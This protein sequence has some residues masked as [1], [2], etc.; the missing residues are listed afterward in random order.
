M[1]IKIST[2]YVAAMLL[3]APA[4]VAQSNLNESLYVEGE[5]APDIVRQDKIHQLPQKKK[6]EFKNQTP[7][8][9][10]KGITSDYRTLVYALPALNLHTMRPESDRRGYFDFGMGQY[11]N[12][13][14]SAGYRFNESLLGES[15]VWLQHNSTSLFRPRTNE[16]RPCERRRMYDETIGF[17]TGHEYPSVGKLDATLRY[18]LGY[19][20][21]YGLGDFGMTPTQTLN[22]LAFTADWSGLTHN[23]ALTYSAALTARYFGYRRGLEPFNT[24]GSRETDLQL[25]GGANMDYGSSGCVGANVAANML[26]Y[27]A[28]R[29]SSE[30]TEPLSPANYGN[31]AFRPYY[32][33]SGDGLYIHA[34]VEVDITVNAGKLKGG[35]RYA[36][37][38][39]VHVAPDVKAQFAAQGVAGYL[40]VTGGTRLQTLA[41]GSEMDTYQAPS[42]LSTLPLY[43][44]ADVKLGINLGPWSGFSAGLHA[45][46]AYTRNRLIG[47][48]TL[49]PATLPVIATGEDNMD[50]KG[51]GAGAEASYEFG[52]QATL[53][54]SIDYSPQHGSHGIFNGYDRPRW[55]MQASL[56][57][58]PVESVDVGLDYTYRGVR[59]IYGYTEM[60][61]A[62]PELFG[63][64]LPDICLL[65]FQASWR[66]TGQL[67]VFGRLNNMLCRRD[68]W[69][70]GQPMEGFNF[71]AGVGVKF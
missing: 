22:D 58:H 47:G 3:S 45:R 27:N 48:W 59:T 63:T 40:S 51:F 19:F 25:S 14:A 10:L 30:Y 53:R 5:Y 50:I 46:Y 15:G 20:N 36:D 1:E 56:A 57:L 23:K 39:S 70:P 18:H 64:R 52:H 62:G 6:F 38:S 28:G 12:S 68:A 41:S 29:G 17:Y 13:A 8:Y 35:A 7:A 66:I 44:P 21:Y 43:S 33:W 49:A 9:A 55:I 24:A 37:F 16:V 69:L 34:G 42:L 67:S 32:E 11:L 2:I 71:M 65:D 54:G 61:G 26:M 4:V 60:A 31:V